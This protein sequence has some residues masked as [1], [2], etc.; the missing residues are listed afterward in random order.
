MDERHPE[1]AHM[2]A[3]TVSREYGSGGG[4][5][6][7]RLAQRLGWELVDHEILVRIAQELG[8]SELEAE[9]HD[10]RAESLVHYL[11][12]SMRVLQ[13]AMFAMET[14]PLLTNMR[15]YREALTK[16]VEAAVTRG[17]VVIVGRGSQVL[18]ANRRDVLHTR[19]VAPVE[20]RVRYVM[21][22]EGLSQSEAE[23]RIQMKDHDRERYLQAQY[24]RQSNDATLY[25]VVINS[26][27]LDLDTVTDLL[28]R[29]L[30]YKAQRLPLPAEKLGPG[31][32]LAR[33][34]GQPG[35][36]RPPTH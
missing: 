1:I 8:I 15:L 13:P 22:R 24:R 23:A 35:D 36:I 20:L 34:P 6:A 2:R 5:V 4:E 26:G 18:L 31:T 3:V 11:I 12:D 9:E 30:D 33:Y 16:V 10:E 17:H 28:Y 32:G 29:A 7:Q 25:D 27:V 14:S 21:Q 19:I